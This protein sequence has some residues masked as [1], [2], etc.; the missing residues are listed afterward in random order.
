MPVAQKRTPRTISFDAVAVQSKTPLITDLCRLFP[1]HFTDVRAWLMLPLSL[2][3]AK[4]HDDLLSK[5]T[6][7]K[8]SSHFYF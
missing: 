6:I 4:H 1:S 7:I 8:T 5:F 2:K 3:P